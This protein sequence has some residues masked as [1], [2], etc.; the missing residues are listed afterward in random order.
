MGDTGSARTG[1]FFSD[2]HRSSPGSRRVHTPASFTRARAVAAQLPRSCQRGDGVRRRCTLVRRGHVLVQVG[3]S[4]STP[5]KRPR[6]AWTAQ[7]APAP[8]RLSAH[9]PSPCLSSAP[10][11]S[12]SYGA[13][14]TQ[15]RR[16][17]QNAAAGF[18]DVRGAL[19]WS[20]APLA[21][22]TAL[23][24]H[25]SLSGGFAQ[26]DFSR[27]RWSRLPPKVASGA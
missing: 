2:E 19:G 10:A 9:A 25:C 17:S 14:V 4:S 16:G 6:S 15:R 20:S 26:P 24:R 12:T 23:S 27:V 22:R 11:V 18:S 21:T 8:G 1:H 3:P 7:R 5:P 13:A